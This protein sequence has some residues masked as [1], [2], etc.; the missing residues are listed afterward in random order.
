MENDKAKSYKCNYCNKEDMSK[1][2]LYTHLKTEHPKDNA[3]QKSITSPPAKAEV[4]PL[5]SS[6]SSGQNDSP[7]KPSGD[8]SPDRTGSVLTPASKRYSSDVKETGVEGQ[9]SNTMDTGRILSTDL[10]TDEWIAENIMKSQEI[11]KNVFIGLLKKHYTKWEDRDI[12]S[13]V[14]DTDLKEIIAEVM[15]E[16]FSE[17]MNQRIQAQKEINMGIVRG[18]KNK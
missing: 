5:Q 15:R 12:I 3:Q 4:H 9:S 7:A 8:V 6:V 2:Q 10:S 14:D 11:A 1:S 18:E 16:R 17:K 13:A